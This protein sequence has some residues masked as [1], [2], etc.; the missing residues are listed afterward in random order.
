MGTFNKKDASKCIFQ[1]LRK[2]ISSFICNF[3]AKER[4][5]V[6]FSLGIV[7]NSQSTICLFFTK[8]HNEGGIAKCIA[9]CRAT[10]WQFCLCTFYKRSSQGFTTKCRVSLRRS[11][12]CTNLPTFIFVFS[13]FLTLQQTIHIFPLLNIF[14]LQ[15]LGC[16]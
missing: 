8:H 14:L 2:K 11:G 16:L 4:Q 7:P 12:V 10:Y 13:F 9:R 3:A 5:I 1:L 6:H 15:L